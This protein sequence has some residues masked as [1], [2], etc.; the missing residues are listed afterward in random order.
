MS[1]PPGGVEGDFSEIADEQLN[2][3]EQRDPALYA[4]VLTVCEAVFPYP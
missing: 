3:L 2:E 4:D 1:N